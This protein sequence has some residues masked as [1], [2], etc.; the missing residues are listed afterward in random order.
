MNKLELWAGSALWIALSLTMM[1]VLFEPVELHAA[2]VDAQT[3]TT[4]AGCM[5]ELAI[6]YETIGL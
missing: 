4:L 3:F 2:V 6:G 1:A 5:A